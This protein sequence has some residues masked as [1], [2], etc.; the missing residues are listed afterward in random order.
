MNLLQVRTQFVKLSGRYDLIVDTTDWVDDGA[1]YYIN[2]G[3]KMLGK[4][5]DVNAEKAKLYYTLDA[6]EY[7]ITFQHHCRV[8]YEVWV[9]N[10]EERYQLT[11]V[12]LT[13][14]KSYY[15]GT[16]T[17]TTTGSPGYFALAEL[18]ALETSDQDSLGTFINKT[19]EET[20]T[21]YDYRGVIIVPPA[22]ESYVVEVSGLFKNVDLSADA[23]KNFWTEEEYELLIRAALYKLEGL[24]RGTENAKNWLSAIRDDVMEINKDIAEEESYGINQLEG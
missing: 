6:N 14:L 24:S 2:S 13:E 9:N 5:A 23:D 22:D 8:I 15:D 16:A 12:P 4:L 20:D 10:D 17:A 7:S 11:K 21:K 18:R 1:N 3:L 19:W